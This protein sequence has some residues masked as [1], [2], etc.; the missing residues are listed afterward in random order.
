MKYNLSLVPTMR[1]MLKPLQ[2]R[3]GLFGFGDG[4]HALPHRY[5]LCTP[6]IREC[7]PGSAHGLVLETRVLNGRA[8]GGWRVRS[9]AGFRDMCAGTRKEKSGE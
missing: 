1:G 5:P 4:D 6:N 7:E 9:L 8:I 2:R 3:R